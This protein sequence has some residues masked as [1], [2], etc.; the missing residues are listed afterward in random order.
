[1]SQV[2]EIRTYR[3][4][5]GTRDTFDRVFAEAA[6][7]MLARW[8]VDVVGF[9]SSLHDP[10]SFYLIRRYDDAAAREK[11]QGAFYGSDEWK[12]GP[13]DA[14]LACIESYVTVVLPM[15]DAAVAALRRV[16]NGKA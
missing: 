7:P 16:A 11:S 12:N 10:D 13:R 3:L 6:G 9:G 15:D 2:V 8:G 4:K 1:M 5:P 14:V